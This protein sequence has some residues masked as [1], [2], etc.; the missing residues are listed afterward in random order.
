[1]RVPPR[2][3]ILL[4]FAAV[5]VAETV[6]AAMIP[7]A[8]LYKDE[9]GLDGTS[10]G[11][12]V[13]SA[14]VAI[15]VAS[16]PAGI[17]VDRV[18]AGWPTVVAAAAIAVSCAGQGFGSSYAV[19]L[20]SRVLYGLGMAFVWTSGII[21]LVELVGPERRTRAIA[22]CVTLAG[23]AGVLG[24]GFAGVLS[25]GGVAVPFAVLGL[26]SAAIAALLAPD[27]AGA[28]GA[29]GHQP[30]L[31]SLRRLRGSVAAVSG[32]VL[33]AI[34]GLAMAGVNLLVPLSFAA[35]GVDAGRVG[36]VFSLSGAAFLATSLVIGRFGERAASLRLTAAAVLGLGALG[37][38]PVVSEQPAALVGYVLARSPLSAVVFTCAFPIAM[39]GALAVG[40]PSGAVLG[41][42]NA[43]WAA[44]TFVGPAGAG[45]LLDVG[46][47]GASYAALAVLTLATGACLAAAAWRAEPRGPAG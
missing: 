14:S 21:W 24:P 11:I 37:L 39:A 22:L 8:P 26:A 29:A 4:L 25:S 38:V 31:D 3:A 40:V 41:L 46:G 33:F 44:A 42:S 36:L 34:G 16:V 45:A 6:W 9:L 27:A 17:V 32:L 30:L 47:R 20:G 18:G 43:I 23:A 19:I 7:L 1:M 13:G 35:D 5:L 28:G 12:L 2:V 15:L 10:T